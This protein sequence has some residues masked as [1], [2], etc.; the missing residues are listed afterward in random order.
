MQ[1]ATSDIFS[2]IIYNGLHINNFLIAPENLSARLNEATAAS[3][4]H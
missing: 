4:S 2:H 3:A 1:Q